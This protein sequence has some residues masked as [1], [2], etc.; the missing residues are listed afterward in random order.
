VRGVLKEEERK[1]RGGLI[2]RG[3]G[4]KGGAYEVHGDLGTLIKVP[5]GCRRGMLPY[6]RGTVPL[7]RC[8]QCSRVERKQD[9]D[10]GHIIASQNL[11]NYTQDHVCHHGVYSQIGD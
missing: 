10:I 7:M 3:V 4:A 1:E 6:H 9:Q 8:C 11:T 5:L 2:Y